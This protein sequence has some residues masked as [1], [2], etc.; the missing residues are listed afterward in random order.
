[1]AHKKCRHVIKGVPVT[2]AQDLLEVR[3]A[4]LWS[5]VLLRVAVLMMVS[6]VGCELLLTVE[7]VT[8]NGRSDTVLRRY[9][10]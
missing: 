10:R 7:T 2:E 1:M 9:I 4:A 5:Q 8:L 3:V 6:E